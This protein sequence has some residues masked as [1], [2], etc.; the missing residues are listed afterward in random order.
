MK[1]AETP[2]NEM[3]RLEELYQLQLLDSLP[4]K[5]YDAITNLASIICGTP[6]S[7]ITLVDTT[8]QYFKSKQGLTVNETPREVAFCAHAILTPN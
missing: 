3:H 4:E 8:R 5:E 7:L 1:I 6:I 2:H